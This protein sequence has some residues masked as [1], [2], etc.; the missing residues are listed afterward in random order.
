MTATTPGAAQLAAL[1]TDFDPCDWPLIA[2]SNQGTLV[3]VCA[4]GLDLVV[5]TPRGPKALW[6]ARRFALRREYR[7]YRRLD[8]VSGF[9]HCFGLFGGCHLALEH[10]EGELLRHVPPANP[11]VFFDRLRSVIEAMHRRGVAHGDL[12]NRENVMIAGN[13][14]PVILDLGTAVV[15]KP[16]WHPL[17]HFVFDYLRRIDRNGFVKLKYGRYDR[18]EGEDRRWVR[19]SLIERVNNWARS[20]G[21]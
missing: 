2:E 3:Q 10:I 4:H 12:K 18:A 5:K 17:N 9:P 19:R 15:R 21:L 20:R 7:A 13:D 11:G 8:G 1:F 6:Y 16:G 14:Y